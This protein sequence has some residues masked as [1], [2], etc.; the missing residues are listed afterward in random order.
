MEKI[1]SGQTFLYRKNGL[2]CTVL[3]VRMK[4]KIRGD[5]LQMAYVKALQRFP[6]MAK[7]L[8]EIDGDFYLEE[9]PLSMTIAKTDKTRQLGSMS[10]NYHLIDITYFENS[11][12]VAFH[13]AL[14]DGRG[15]KPFLET[16]IYYYCCL[17]YNKKLDSSGIRLAGEPLLPGETDEPVGE[18][19]FDVD[20]ANLPQI[21]KDGYR[22]PENEE[23]C[24]CYYRYELLIDKSGFIKYM[25]DHEATPAILLALLVSDSIYSI[26]PD[27]DKP[28]VCSLAVDYRNEIGLE[29]THKNCVGSLYLPFTEETR[30]MSVAEQAR[31][32]RELMKEQRKPDAIKNMINTQIGLCERL[33]QL[34]SLEE[35]RLALDFFNDMCIDTYVISYLGQIELGDREVYVDSIHLYN[36]GVQG[37]RISVISAGDYFSVNI[38]Q[39]FESEEIVASL[40]KTLDDIDIAYSASERIRF[41]TLKDMA[42][43]TAG[44]QAER[45]RRILNKGK[46]V[47]NAG[48]RQE[49]K[50]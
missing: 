1:R 27:A 32:Y 39:D 4:Q 9:N 35:K 20:K 15:I 47:I 40:K 49:A 12:C 25:K 24:V 45:Y 21:I 14:C 26:H 30:K 5:Y 6:Y 41:A 11:F 10:T 7:K 48:K 22:L 43:V 36:S 50:T 19:M 13:H 8:V 34:P 2:N 46:A 44:R 42:Y 38:K 3:D 29:N 18:S 31:Y 37:L 23:V 28:I 33:D 17:R 16:L